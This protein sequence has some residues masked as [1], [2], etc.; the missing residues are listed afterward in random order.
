MLKL[1]YFGHLMGRAYSSE[2]ILMLGNIEDKRRREQLWMRWVDSINDSMNMRLSKLQETA[3]TG[4][5]QLMGS[6]RLD[7]TEWMKNNSKSGKFLRSCKW[8]IPVLV[9]PTQENK[10][11][12]KN[13]EKSIVFIQH[14]SLEITFTFA[15]ITSYSLILKMWIW[16]CRCAYFQRWLS[17]EYP[18]RVSYL[19]ILREFAWPMHML[20]CVWSSSR[21]GQL[22]LRNGRRVETWLRVWAAAIPRKGEWA[23]TAKHNQ[24]SY[25]QGEVWKYFPASQLK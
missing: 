1:Q 12:N 17:T 8:W 5:L 11:K 14:L 2:K 18:L 16:R 25:Q 4:I 19:K 20:P 23:V 13:N 7:M 22:R 10:N 21:F 3:K 24:P 9:G 6:Q 15:N